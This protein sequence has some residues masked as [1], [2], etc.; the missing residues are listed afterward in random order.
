MT[1]T[2]FSAFNDQY[3][4]YSFN[5]MFQICVAFSWNIFVKVLKSLEFLWAQYVSLLFNSTNMILILVTLIVA[6]LNN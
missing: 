4:K 1:E 6:T 5:L 3:F 2:D